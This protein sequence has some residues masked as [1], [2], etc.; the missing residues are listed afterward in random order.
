MD[1]V[2]DGTTSLSDAEDWLAVG[3]GAL[4]PLVGASRRSAIGALL[5]A[6]SAPLL[7]RG[8]A[9]VV[10][11]SGRIP[12]PGRSIACASIRLTALRADGRTPEFIKGECR[13]CNPILAVGASDQLLTACGIDAA[14]PNGRPDPGVITTSDASTASDGFIAA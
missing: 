10:R 13:H 7:Y 12:R 1:A 9:A 14:L 2:H 3:S 4:V 11:T 6:S 5:A 8:I